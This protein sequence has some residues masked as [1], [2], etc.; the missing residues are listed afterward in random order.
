[1]RDPVNFFFGLGFPLVL[2]VLLSI[3]NRSI[4]AEAGN[5]MFEISNLASG[6]AMFGSV[7][8]AL[9]AGMLRFTRPYLI[10]FNALVYVSD[11]VR[12]FYFGLHAADARYDDSAGGDNLSG[13]ESF[14]A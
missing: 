1:M 4:P 9:F 6:L 5:P 7:F 3:I 2:L 13:G 10:F 8:M 11:D 12:R 14:W